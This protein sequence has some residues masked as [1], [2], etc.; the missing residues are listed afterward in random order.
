[1][2]ADIGLNERQRGS[3][4]WMLV[5]AYCNDRLEQ[6]RRENDGDLDERRTAKVRGRIAEIQKFL[7]AGAEPTRDVGANAD[8]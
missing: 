8:Q 2:T 6:L 3:D 4:T 5:V 1:M 7:R